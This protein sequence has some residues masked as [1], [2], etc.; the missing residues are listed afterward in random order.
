MK[1]LV[2]LLTTCTCLVRCL[3]PPHPDVLA[4]KWE[5]ER[6]HPLQRSPALRNPHLRQVLP[7]TSL[8]HKGENLVRTQVFLFFQYLNDETNTK[9]VYG[10]VILTADILFSRFTHEMLMMCRA[11]KYIK[12]SPTQDWYQGKGFRR[13]K[14]FIKTTTSL[15]LGLKSGANNSFMVHLSFPTRTSYS[16]CKL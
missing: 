11:T 4:V 10:N 5:E 12:S 16:T 2:V 14:R 15:L 8:L 7:L 13:P 6:L 9:P 1:T 3:P